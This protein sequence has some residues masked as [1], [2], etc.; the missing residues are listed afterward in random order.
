MAP[1]AEGAFLTATT[2]ATQQGSSMSKTTRRG[3]RRFQE[4]LADVRKRN[5][6][7]PPAEVGAAVDAAVRAVRARIDRSVIRQENLLGE[8]E[9]AR[10][11]SVIIKISECTEL[12]LLADQDIGYL[13]ADTF[14]PAPVRLRIGA[15]RSCGIRRC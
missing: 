10:S 4:S 5:R 9:M 8:P 3:L 11:T 13:Q 7:V 1:S 6:D 2:G 12:R 15:R 14:S